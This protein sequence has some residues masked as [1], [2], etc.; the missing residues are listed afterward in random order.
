[1]ESITTPPVVFDNSIDFE[2][3]RQYKE[4][5][6][7]NIDTFAEL[8]DFLVGDDFVPT[9]TFA[10]I[11]TPIKLNTNMLTN[12]E[13]VHSKLDNFVF[14]SSIQVTEVSGWG[15]NTVA[16]IKY[17]AKKSCSMLEPL[18]VS[19]YI[20]DQRPIMTIDGDGTVVSPSALFGN[21]EEWWVNLDKY[22]GIIF[23]RDHK[24]ILEVSDLLTNIRSLLKEESLVENTIIS[25][26]KPIDTEN[27][28]Q[29]SVHSPVNIGV[30]DKNGNFTGK[31]CIE[32]VCYIEEGIPNSSYLEFGEGKYVDI[33]ETDY[34]KTILT[35]YDTGTFTYEIEKTKP[36]GTSTTTSFYDIPTTPLMKAEV[37]ETDS[38][39][40]LKI[41]TNGDGSIDIEIG[42]QKEFDPIL[43][44]EIIKKTVEGLDLNDGRKNSFIKRVDN[45]IKLIGKGKIDKV[46]LRSENFT[47]I[48]Q[49]IIDRKDPKN[50]PKNP[51]QGRLTKADAEILLKMFEELL[52]N[53]NK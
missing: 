5:Y 19:K 14:P 43:S 9:P 32:N 7:D 33:K 28:M 30:Y 8:Q 27:R 46:K 49:K 29:L 38:K 15:I 10:N 53:L 16:S 25:K 39:P 26:T 31:V 11:L 21:G 22:N 47:K 20:L 36:D 42:N 24:N 41:D 44:L 52:I 17:Q 45:L 23:K 6:G 4:K 48:L 35:G 12:A 34:N 50:P 3:T 2:I 13:T 18:C 37:T 1:M 40:I 51:Q